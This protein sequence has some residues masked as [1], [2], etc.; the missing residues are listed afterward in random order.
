MI[1]KTERLILRE[2]READLDR[3][4]AT[5]S[6]P[7]A[8]RFWSTQPDETPDVTRERLDF[9]IEDWA[10]YHRNFEIEMDG[11]WI[12]GAGMYRDYEVGFMLS[13]PYWRQGI[14]SEAMT[15]IIP[16]LFETIGVP[17]MT[18][19]A[20]PLNAASCGI[21]NALGFHETHRAKN[22]FCINDV[23]SDSVYFRLD[24]PAA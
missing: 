19:D 15:A 13:R 17:Y 10:K 12:G 18:A 22:T 14:I 16:H 3:M 6:D 8:M 7:E 1:L 4:F 23:W 5:Y 24:P 20:D 9:R 2:P 11:N 21:L